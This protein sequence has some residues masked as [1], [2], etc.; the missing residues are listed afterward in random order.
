[1]QACV[2]GLQAETSFQLGLGPWLAHL[3]CDHLMFY[4]K[5]NQ[6]KNKPKTKW[7]KL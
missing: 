2:S 4:F 3:D 7:S 6:Q 1:M 5:P